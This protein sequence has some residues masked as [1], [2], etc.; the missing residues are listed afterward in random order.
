MFGDQDYFWNNTTSVTFLQQI[1]GM[2][3]VMNLD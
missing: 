2:M 3:S 1:L